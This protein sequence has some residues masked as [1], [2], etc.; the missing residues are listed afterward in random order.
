MRVAALY[1]VHGNT[2]ALDA[3]LGDDRF[4]AADLVV[5]GGDVIVGPDPAGVLEQLEGLGERVRFLRGNGDRE[6]LAPGDAEGHFA[7]IAAWSRDRLNDEQRE[8]VGRWPAT[9]EVDIDGLGRVLFCHATPRSDTELVTRLTP[10]DEVVDILSEVDATVVVCGHVH[11]QYDRALHDGRRI[12][13]AGSVGMPYEGEP[14]AFW[15]LLGPSVELCRTEYDLDEAI[16]AIEE[17][18]YA[19]VRDLVVESLRG[20]AAPDD[21]TAFFESRRGA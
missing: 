17:T 20:G 9:V 1:D 5:V 12:V 8:R 13:N 11:V 18:G 4:A 16:A 2:P 3:V 21:V 19:D 15:A 6:A 7:E 14:G 10:D